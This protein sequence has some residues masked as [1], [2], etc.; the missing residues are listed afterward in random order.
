MPEQ[1]K[2][3]QSQED[4][5]LTEFSSVLETESTSQHV[6]SKYI[7]C[8]S[9]GRSFRIGLPHFVFTFKSPDFTMFWYELKVML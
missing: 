7:T 5:P 2:S 6:Y 4:L 9:H 1:Q 3:F 8:V